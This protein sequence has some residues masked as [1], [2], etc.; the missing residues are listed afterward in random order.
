MHRWLFLLISLA[1]PAQAAPPARIEVAYE[2]T[3]DGS[4]MAEVV[5]VL[6]H[7]GGRYQITETSSGRGIYSIAGRMKRTS[8]GLVDAKSVRPIEFLDERPGRDSRASFDWQGRTV[9]MQYKEQ[10]Q[11]VPM[12]A[13]AQDRLSFL[14]AFSLFPPKAKSVTYNIADGRGFSAQLYRIAGPEKVKTPAGEF[15]ALKLV[16]TKEQE[17]GKHQ[18]R[19]EIWLAAELGNFPVRA[20]VID[21]EGRRLE[22][23]A[24]RVSVS[25]P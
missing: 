9:T 1:G 4:V 12:P 6:E 13:D 21:K 14:L 2:M 15:S 22:Q 7:G 24:V 19:A 25:A 5:E 8:R 16:R 20:L 18:E 11:T 23:M 3:R 17:P 10:R